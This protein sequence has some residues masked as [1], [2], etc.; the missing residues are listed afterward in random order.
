MS[1]R[2]EL[3]YTTPV[4][5]ER[6]GPYRRYKL[7]IQKQPGTLSEL[8]SVQIQLPAGATVIHTTPEVADSYTLDQPILEFRL[9]L[10]SDEQIEV[11]Y[12]E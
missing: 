5:D 2:L 1:E 3:S 11:I 4:L 9:E 12:V 7:T 8:A 6:I 10:L